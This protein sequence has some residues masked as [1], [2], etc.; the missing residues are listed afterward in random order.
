[1]GLSTDNTEGSLT[2]KQKEIIVGSLLGDG[3]MRI[4]TNALLEINHNFGQKELV[5]WMYSSLKQ[6]VGTGPKVRKGNGKRIAYRFTTKSLPIFT[7]FYN[8][9]F[10]NGRK[11]IPTYINLSP[12]VLAVWF[13]GDGSKS[14]SSIYLNTQQFSLEEQKLLCKMLY[15][16]WQIETTLNKDKR[17]LRI[18][19]RVSSIEK[20]VS[21]IKPYLLKQFYY[22]LPYDPVSTDGRLMVT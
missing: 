10:L 18:R 4:K 3:T 14:R 7:S 9:F 8:R 16:Q 13:M 17:Y 5:D 20:F 2:E 22:K 21:L 15:K 11:K 12:L 19:I 1:M 6:F